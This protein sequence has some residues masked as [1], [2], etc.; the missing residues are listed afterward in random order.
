MEKSRLHQLSSP[1]KWALTAYLL[2]T[3]LGFSVAALMSHLHYGWSHQQ[4]KLYYLGSETEMAFPKLY[5]E[6]LQTAHVHSFT[7]PMVFFILW[8]SLTYLP[9]KSGFKKFFIVGGAL[10]ILVYNAA[11]F[12][13]RFVSPKWVLLFSVGGIGLFVFFLSPTI[14]VLY[15]T[16][17]GMSGKIPSQKG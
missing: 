3:T 6:L 4:T 2:L 15:D 1:A 17:F 14:L 5:A 13:L 10:S 7:M 8:W 12:M 11:P 9:L 16:W